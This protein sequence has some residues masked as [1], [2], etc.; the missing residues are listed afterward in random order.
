M[1][2]GHEPE[3]PHLVG[4]APVAIVEV[5]PAKQSRRAYT[6]PAAG[7]RYAQLPGA[8]EAAASEQSV[9]GRH[10]ER[11]RR[12]CPWRPTPPLRSSH[13]L[14]DWPWLKPRGKEQK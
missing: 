9:V 8:E 7:G 14:L 6:C 5:E 3:R 11:Q 2:R 13:G 10:T 4:V 1:E 12:I